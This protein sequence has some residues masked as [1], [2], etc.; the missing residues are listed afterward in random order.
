MPKFTIEELK[1]N[2][3]TSKLIDIRDGRIYK[4]L[5]NSEHGNE[6]KN[7][8]AFSFILNTDGIS[9][10][11]KSKLTI[12]PVFLVI[13]ELPIESR[14]CIDN[15]ILA[16]LS[17]AE[18][19]PNIDIFFNEI[20]TQLSILEFGIDVSLLHDT[21]KKRKFFLI[22]AI[23]DKPAKA[24]VLNMNQ[25]NGNCG[26]TKCEQPG[27]T[28]RGVSTSIDESEELAK[29]GWIYRFNEKNPKGPMRT[30]IDYEN[31]LKKA[32]ETKSIVKGIKGRC[33]L[34]SLKYFKPV[35][36]TC[37]DY[38]HSLLEGVV[39]SFFKYWFC[40]EIA[41]PY[42][43][44]KYMQEID[45]RLSQISPPTFV[46]STPR[47]IYTH[48]VWRAHEY[49]SFMLYYALPVFRDI[50]NGEYYNNIKKLIIF[51][52][53]LLSPSISLDDLSK[54]ELI[55]FDFVKEVSKLYPATIL[56]SGLHELLHLVDCTLDFGPLNCTNCFQF[57]EINRKLMRF[58]H[59]ADLIGEELIKIFSTG[60][61][62]YF[63]YHLNYLIFFYFSNISSNS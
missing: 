35:S 10:M 59:G 31:N 15:I 46:P 41:D 14:F 54:A 21:Q 26:C 13:N 33:V 32:I 56:L 27:E 44:K 42:S 49:L 24:P 63:I 12:W 51:M 17:V 22:A 61:Y 48:N 43:L 53:I 28:A 20:V 57:E 50:M 18:H 8:T 55:I 23:F 9:P 1:H 58:L 3:N 36:S 62:F 29:G 16:G 19:K 30:D 11:K 34:S 7:Q 40:G 6:F 5:I 37:I 25:F 60:I 45:F 52:E 39:K 4:K 47:S 2:N 38:M